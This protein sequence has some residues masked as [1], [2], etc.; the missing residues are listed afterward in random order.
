M[1]VTYSSEYQYDGEKICEVKDPLE[2]SG[3]VRDDW[4]GNIEP[5]NV[6]GGGKQ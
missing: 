4:I 5:V 1:A 2:D 3:F 6:T